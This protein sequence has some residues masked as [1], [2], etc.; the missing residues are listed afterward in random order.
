MPS[1]R[2]VGDDGRVFPHVSLEV[3]P[4][5]VVECDE[6]PNPRYFE[7]VA[8]LMGGLVSKPLTVPTED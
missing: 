3:E 4:G 1:F 8:N 6:N 7:P 2:Y 5:D